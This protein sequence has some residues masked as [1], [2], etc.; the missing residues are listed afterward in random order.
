MALVSQFLGSLAK[1]PED[2]GSTGSRRLA[3]NAVD[4]VALLVADLLE[5]EKLRATGAGRELLV[6]IR[7]HIEANLMDPELSPESIARVHHI[8]VRYLH[9]LFQVEGTSVSAW[10][11]RHRLDACRREL[12]RRR[13][14]VAA[15]AQSWGFSSASHFSRLF[16]ETYG[17]SPT[18][19]Q[20]LAS[21]DS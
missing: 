11:R 7:A 1:M 20:T 15:V 13:R 16:R 18:E 21:S 17:V 8:S 6:R 4:L 12:G 9:K 14:T 5:T 2:P 10:I 19:W 3:L